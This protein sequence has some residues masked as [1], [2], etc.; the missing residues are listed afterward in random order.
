MG[1]WY[2]LSTK[3]NRGTSI[4]GDGFPK[5][6]RRGLGGRDC[7]DALCCA[8]LILPWLQSP[9]RPVGGP[10]RVRLGVGCWQPCVRGV[11]FGIHHCQLG[12]SY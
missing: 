5:A 8:Q 2:V 4:A 10:V 7:C 12:S 11:W 1:G 6:P 3:P 9:E